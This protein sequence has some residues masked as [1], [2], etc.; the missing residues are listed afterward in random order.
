MN[1][2]LTRPD[3]WLARRSLTDRLAMLR[4]A[5]SGICGCLRC[6][7]EGHGVQLDRQIAGCLESIADCND[8]I[9]EH[10]TP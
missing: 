4:I 3:L 5:R 6:N 2:T 7:D 9:C 10:V 8:R 1:T